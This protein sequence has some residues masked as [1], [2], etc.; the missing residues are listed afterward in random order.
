MRDTGIGIDPAQMPR[1][2]KSFTQADT[3]T[4]RRFGG[5]G[6]GLAISKR[7]VE[8]MG[9][10]IWAESEPGRGSTFHFTARFN[11][12]PATTTHHLHDLTPKDS[13]VPG[14]DDNKPDGEAPVRHHPTPPP[15]AQPPDTRDHDI[16]RIAGAR[17]LLVEDNE[18]NRE[19]AL[20][21]LGNAGLQVVAANDGR[22]ALAILAKDSAFDGILMDIQMPVMDGYTATTE[23]RKI[24]AFANL[25]ILAMT[26][27]AMVGDRERALQ[28]G[29]NDHIPKPV[30]LKHLFRTLATWI[31]PGPRGNQPAP[32]PH[33]DSTPPRVPPRDVHAIP[34][35][36]ARAGLSRLG[37][38]LPLYERLLLKFRD[39]Q[40]GF[41]GEVR[42]ALRTHD[43]T[44][45]HRLAHTLKGLAGN[46]GAEGVHAATAAFEQACVESN[47]DQAA[48]ALEALETELD[49]LLNQLSVFDSPPTPD[50]QDDHPTLDSTGSS[51]AT[52]TPHHPT[53]RDT[54]HLQ[55]LLDRLES[56]LAQDDGLATEALDEILLS[57][58]APLLAA[59]LKRI[60][61]SVEA[62]A[63]E[64]ALAQVRQLRLKLANAG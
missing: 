13:R 55:A 40:A 29:M 18:M 63:Y 59:E 42:K 41:A 19:L 21:I 20:E 2:F 53:S 38:N 48:P 22:E 44:T 31:K 8:L 50:P 56:L 12:P 32:I 57:P 24:P 54:S 58:R 52:T 62:Y 43:A 46:I 1:L 23:I 30:S 17:L 61:K 3:S 4:T 26:A 51:P 33:P 14:S 27:N 60:A 15:P 45:A 11:A 34:G 7:I 6:L 64:D 25:P 10:R 28:A 49:R 5:T 36:N 35:L 47:P 16:A 37:G 9:G 39:S